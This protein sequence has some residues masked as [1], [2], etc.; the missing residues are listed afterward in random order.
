MAREHYE[1]RIELVLH[2][3]RKELQG[4]ADEYRTLVLIPLCRRY[5]LTFIS[6]MGRTVFYKQDGRSAGSAE[7]AI[8]EKM[9]YLVPIFRT[10]D[11]EAIG[12]N[13]CFGYYVSDINESDISG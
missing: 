3:A 5:R 8:S 12:H 10:L 9:S 1:S 13:D 7:E 2:A 4:L 11:T 6:G